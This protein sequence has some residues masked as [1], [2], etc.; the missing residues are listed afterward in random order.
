MQFYANVTAWETDAYNCKDACNVTGIF[1]YDWINDRMR[2][3]YDTYHTKHPRERKKIVFYWWG[4][5]HQAADRAPAMPSG[6]AHGNFYVTLS[7]PIKGKICQYFNYTGMTIPK[8]DM[9]AQSASKFAGREFHDKTWGDRYQ[10]YL[11][12]PCGHG[13][14]NAWSNIYTG[15]PLMD[16]GPNRCTNDTQNLAETHWIGVD[17]GPHTTPNDLWTDYEFKNCQEHPQGRDARQALLEGRVDELW[18]HLDEQT[19]GILRQFSGHATRFMR[20][21]AALDAADAL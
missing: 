2:Q 20:A 10:L 17:A 18:G 19:A 11:D 16:H 9:W 12:M 7:V 6:A 21:Q 5:G 3:N 15:Y 13:M 4:T 8:P 14:F 1:V